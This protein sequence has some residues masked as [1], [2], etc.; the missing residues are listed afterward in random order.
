MTANEIINWSLRIIGALIV[1]YI[2]Y[3]YKTSQ[4][5]LKKLEDDSNDQ[6]VINQSF[7]DYNKYKNEKDK[8]FTSTVSVILEKI[9]D[10]KD[11]FDEKIGDLTNE[12]HKLELKVVGKTK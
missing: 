5:R 1:A 11:S 9:G 2:V 4:S 6:K 3:M 8:E 10:L 7:S 12:I